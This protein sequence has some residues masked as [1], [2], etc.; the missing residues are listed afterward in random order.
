MSIVSGTRQESPAPAAD[1]MDVPGLTRAEF[2]RASVGGI[3]LSTGA[4]AAE[5]T[6]SDPAIRAGAML[7]RPIPSTGKVIPVIGLGTWQVFP[8][9]QEIAV[10][11]GNR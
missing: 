3:L 11:V 4:P 7:T 2:L 9:A 5:Q 8:S 6:L 10:D 1:R